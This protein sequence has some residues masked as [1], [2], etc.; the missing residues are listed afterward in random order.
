[1]PG[2]V[3]GFGNYFLPIHCGAPDMAKLNFLYYSSISKI[4]EDNL[5]ILK[6]NVHLT[7]ST[8]EMKSYLGSYL[9][10]LYE[11]DGHISFSEPE[12]KNQYNPRFNITFNIKDK[13]LAEKLL[14]LIKKLSDI[15]TGFIR[16]KN[17]QNACVITLS[18]PKV[19]IFIVNLMNGK[20]RGP[21]IYTFHKLID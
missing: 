14:F 13:P 12:S 5:D 9:A 20:L 8:D 21:K 7:G 19:L 1:M 16:L 2:L 11:G 18:N 4:V 15:N 6:L 10:G 3:G 17:E